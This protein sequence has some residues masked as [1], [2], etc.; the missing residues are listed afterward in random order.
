[1]FF[2]TPTEVKDSSVA[3]DKVIRV[4]GLVK[5]GSVS[6]GKLVIEFVLTD[7]KSD[8]NVQYDGILPDLFREGQGIIATGK[9]EN[10]ILKSTNLLAKHDE[11]YI[12]KELYKASIDQNACKDG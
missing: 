8:I 12:P 5:N 4:G 1:M 11:R 3:L 7:C 10:G 2:M 6:K 9:M